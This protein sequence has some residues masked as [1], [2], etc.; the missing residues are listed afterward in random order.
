MKMAKI[1]V[2]IPT[3]PDNIIK[4]QLSSHQLLANLQ[5]R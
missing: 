2:C 4:T 1:H 3:F 5:V